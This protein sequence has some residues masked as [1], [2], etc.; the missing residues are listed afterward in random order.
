[1]EGQKIFENDLTYGIGS[2]SEETDAQTETDQMSFDWNEYNSHGD[3]RTVNARYQN[4]FDAGCDLKR[5]TFTF[6]QENEEGEEIS[7]VLPLKMEVCPTCQGRGTHVDPSVDAGGYYDDGDDCDEYGEN[8]YFSG[9]YDVVC[10]TCHG[11]NV[12]AGIDRHMAEK[13]VL[14]VWDKKSEDDEEFEAMCR[15]ERRMGA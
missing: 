10:R 15:A 9:A 7:F 4:E 6:V 2:L 8:L 13:E 5:M 11:K 1:M 3:I 14:K 12:V